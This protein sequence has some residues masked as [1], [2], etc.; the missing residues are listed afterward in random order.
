MHQKLVPDSF[1]ILVN[2]PKQPLHVIIQRV[3]YFLLY[4]HLQI[5]LFGSTFVWKYF[6]T[7]LC[8]HTLLRSW[9]VKAWVSVING[10]LCD[11]LFSLIPFWSDYLSSRWML[12]LDKQNYNKV[13]WNYMAKSRCQH[14]ILWICRVNFYIFIFYLP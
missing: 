8:E 5:F 9:Y 12:F 14:N 4:Q 7:R 10:L 2:N 13:I 1:L 6:E 11:I 3:R